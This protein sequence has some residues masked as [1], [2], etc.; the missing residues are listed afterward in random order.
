MAVACLSQAAGVCYWVMVACWSFLAD[1]TRNRE[2]V[3]GLYGVEIIMAAA[4]LHV[5][6]LGP[7]S[8]SPG[9]ENMSVRAWRDSNMW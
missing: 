8:V 6:G 3:V 5:G 1:W 7:G 4:C 2:V 9:L